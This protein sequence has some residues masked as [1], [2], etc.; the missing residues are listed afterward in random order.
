LAG[1]GYA[2]H[3]IPSMANYL[4]HSFIDIDLFVSGIIIGNGWVD[5]YYQYA[6]YPD[7]AWEN[8]LV[9][10]GHYVVVKI[11]YEFC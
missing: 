9:T 10:R 4:E 11:F 7:Y 5:P 1:E 6:S 8:Q 3:F 2:G